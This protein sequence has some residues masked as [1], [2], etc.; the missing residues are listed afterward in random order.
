MDA[1]NPIEDEAVVAE[2]LLRCEGALELEDCSQMLPLL[3]RAPG[4]RVWHVKGRN[5]CVRGQKKNR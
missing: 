2:L 3:R 4:R 1:F 5:R